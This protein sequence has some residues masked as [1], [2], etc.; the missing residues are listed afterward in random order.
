MQVMTLVFMAIAA[1]TKNSTG[2]FIGPIAN[3]ANLSLPGQLWET[4]QHARSVR[5]VM[6][7]LLPTLS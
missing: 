5:A 1:L 6:E 4:N 2:P 7:T 3:S